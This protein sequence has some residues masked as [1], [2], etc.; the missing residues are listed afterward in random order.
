MG[1]Q[2][3]LT[4]CHSYY[5]HSHIIYLLLC[6]LHR[7]CSRH[8][9]CGVAIVCLHYELKNN[10]KMFE[11][12]AIYFNMEAMFTISQLYNSMWKLCFFASQF[13]LFDLQ[14]YK[15]RWNPHLRVSHFYNLMW[16]LSIWGFTFLQLNG[17]SIFFWLTILQLNVETMC[18]LAS[19]F[20]NS[21]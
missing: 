20:Y 9:N 19:Q 18:F 21:M 3:L 5:H 16:E 15:S 2:S 8:T 10:R 17:G 4:V 6:M 14:F 1:I 11:T 13:Y 12:T 7:F